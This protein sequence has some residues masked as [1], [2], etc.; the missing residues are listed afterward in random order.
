MQLRK[1][2]LSAV[3][4]ASMLASTSTAVFAKVPLET[5]ASE[6]AFSAAKYNVAEN[7]GKYKVKVMRSGGN[8]RKVSVAFKTAD[9]MAVYGEDYVVLNED[10]SEIPVTE[11]ISPDAE[12][13]TEISGTAADDLLT[14]TADADEVAEVSEAV[15]LGETAEQEIAAEDSKTEVVINEDGEAET[16]KSALEAAETEEAEAEEPTAD[17]PTG[18]TSTGSSLLDAQAEY[19]NLPDTNAATAESVEQALT[20]VNDYFASARGAVGVVVFDEGETEKEITIKIIDNDKPEADKI[21]LLSLMGVNGDDNTSLAA[22]PTAY[23]NILDDEPYEKPVIEPELTNVTLTSDNPVYELKL[24]R[25]AGVDYY[26]SVNVTTTANTAV[27]D[28]DFDKMDDASVAFAPGET[29][30]TVKLSAKN[31]DSDKSYGLRIESDGTCDVTSDYVTV[32]IEAKKAEAEQVELMSGG[33]IIGQATTSAN[34]N[35]FDSW[36]EIKKGG[37]DHWTK[38]VEVAG[39]GFDLQAKELDKNHGIGWRSTSTHNYYGIDSIRCHVMVGGD[40][41]SG[42]ESRLQLSSDSGFGNDSSDGGTKLISGKHDWDYYTLNVDKGGNYY[43]KVKTEAKC[44]GRDN[45]MVQ[46]GNPLENNWRQYTLTVHNTQYF[47]RYQYDYADKNGEFEIIPFTDGG[48]YFSYYPKVKMVTSDETE[49]SGFYA[50]A[51]QVIKPV[52]LDPEQDAKYGVELEGVYLYVKQDNELYNKDDFKDHWYEGNTIFIKTS[53]VTVN[54]DLAKEIQDKLGKDAKDI[55]VMPKFK[56]KTVKVNVYNADSEQT[57]IA[58]LFD[59]ENNKVSDF[60][61]FHNSYEFPLYSK[62]K[63]RAVAAADKK[64]TGFTVV[65]NGKANPYSDSYDPTKMTYSID[66]PTATVVNIYPCTSNQVMDIQYMP[67][68]TKV[69]D[70]LTDRV[71]RQDTLTDAGSPTYASDK[72]GNIHIE[73]VYTGMNWIMRATPPEGYYVKWKNGTGD[74][75]I[76]NG[77]IDISSTNPDKN[78]VTANTERGIYH[79]VYGDIMSGT[80]NQDDTKYYYWFAKADSGITSSVTGNVQR[81]TGSF[82]DVVNNKK[83]KK[84]PAKSTQVSIAGTAVYTDEYGDFEAVLQ[85]VPPADADYVSVIVDN[86]GT[87]YP[88]VALANYMEITLPAY[89]CFKP[90]SL[91]VSYIDS[92]KYPIDGTTVNI[93]NNDLTV[94]AGVE[95]NGSIL[96]VGAKFYIHKENG[97]VIDCSDPAD[98]R[99]ETSFINGIGKLTIKTAKSVLSM[100]DKIYVAFVDQYG[101]K[102]KAM[103]IGYSFIAPLNLRTF[104]FPLIGSTLVD[105][106]YSTATELIGDPLGNISLGTLKFSDPETTS[107]TPKNMDPNKYTYIMSTYRF[108]DYSKAITTFNGKYPEKKDPKESPKPEETSK[109]EASDEPAPPPSASDEPAPPADNDDPAPPAST[110]E[111]AAPAADEKLAEAAKDATKEGG[112]KTEDGGYKTAKSFSWSLSPKAAFAMQISTRKD[113]DGEYR[114]Y[115]EQ[116]EFLV[117]FDFKVEGKITVTLPIGVNIVIT[118]GLSGDVTGV[119]QLKT[120]Y[121]GDPT[122][123]NNKVEYSAASFG[124]FEEIEHVNRTAYFMINPKISLGLG[125]SFASI[126]VGGHANFYFDMDFKFGLNAGELSQHMYGAM[127]YDFDYYVKV[128][129][130]KV[131]SGKKKVSDPIKLFSKNADGPIDPGLLSL[132]DGSDEIQ[133]IPVTREYLN[134]TSEWNSSMD[135]VSLFDIDTSDGTT[136]ALLQ[137]GVYPSSKFKI[138]KFGDNNILMLFIGDV[139]TRSAVNRTGLF[140]SIYDGTNW[141]TPALV[142]DD[143][144]LDDYP[145][146]IDLGDKILVAWSSA[147]RVLDDNTSAPQALTALDIKVSFF[148]KTDKSFSTAE[149]ITKTT[150]ADY[151]ADTEPRA[152]YDAETDRVILYYTKTEYRDENENY[153]DELD[154]LANADSVIAYRFYENGKW[155]D[156]ESYTSNELTGVADVDTYKTNWYGQRFLDTRINTSSNDMLRIIDSDACYYNGLALYAWTVDYDKDL[157]TT[158]DR[159][160]FVQIYNFSE[161]SFTHIIRMTA[162]SGSYSTPHFGR[163]NDNTYLFFSAVGDLGSGEAENDSGIA[164]I[165]ISKAISYNQY[166]LK[167]EDSTKY[168]IL[169]YNTTVEASTDSAGNTVPEHKVTVDI[170]PVYA[171]KVNG[172]VNNYSVDVDENERMYLTWTDS[173]TGDTASRQVFTSIY[174]VKTEVTNDVEISEADWSEPFMLTKAD[175]TAYSNIDAA[176]IDGKLY[177]AANKTPYTE[178]DGVTGLD[179]ANTSM[180][181]LKHTPYSKPV[182]LEED[183]LTIDTKYVYPDTPFTLT[184]SVKN[185]GVKFIEEPVTFTFS[186]T[187]GGVTTD[188]GTETFDGL[189]GAGKTLSASVDITPISEISDDLTFNAVVTVGSTVIN[190]SYKAIKEYSIIPDG[191]AV[192]AAKTD[193]HE[194]SLPLRNDGNIPSESVSVKLYTAKDGEKDQLINEFTIESIA[195]NSTETIDEM[196]DVP[197]E[198]Y[199]IEDGEGIADIIVVVEAGGEEI[200]TLE[201]TAH[202]FFDAQAIETMSKITGVSIKG[203]DKI[204]VQCLNDINIETKITGDASDDAKVIWMSSDTNVVYVRSDGTLCGIEKGTATLTGYVVPDVQNIVFAYDGTATTD[205]LLDSIP[206]NMYKTVTAEVTVTDEPVPTRKPSSGGGSSSSGATPKPTTTVAPSATPDVEPTEAPQASQTPSQPSAGTAVFNDTVN[207]WAREYIERLAAAGIINGVS[208][209]TFEPDGDIT[210]AQFAQILMQTGL[211]SGGAIEVPDYT[212]VDE[213][214]WYYEAVR[215]AVSNGVAEGMS[216]KE[217]APDGRITREQMAAMLNRFITNAGIEA[218]A[219]SEVVFKDADSISDWAK[220]NVEALA[221]TGIISGRD[222]GEFDPQANMTRAEGTVVIC[223]ILDL[224]EE[225]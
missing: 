142:D 224:K 67:T 218:E 148:D 176:V 161:N 219:V 129:S 212:D 78:E 42:F 46:L 10:G 87:Q 133:N 38:K 204:T 100:G 3:I 114:Y 80:I 120:D 109:P 124:L 132:Y 113:P 159:D 171:V 141:S 205:N 49:V 52:S 158:N 37:D 23:I 139:T 34:L 195:E 54:Q 164:Y 130:I 44:A 188:L 1:R 25:T 136:E 140:Y 55:K 35:V 206:S 85:N 76:I 16:A 51:N 154:E 97:S 222:T 126:E 99:F 66:D 9:F 56:Q 127:T 17:E 134:N 221:K 163:Y 65:E 4:A 73:S 111:P 32:N 122:W 20:E 155:N 216:D 79:S 146:A 96:P 143:S 28:A 152:A 160:V 225:K 138:T 115:F 95:S 165:N 92:A 167:E 41:S 24:L 128:L 105:D 59:A 209:S 203:S 15:L 106:A 198:A 214:A 147:D 12:D 86:E 184:S 72:D 63:M 121:N 182:T 199:A 207:H 5:G 70:D 2:I 193:G 22:N 94:E 119:F 64:I 47:Y 194:L 98:T 112:E 149:K 178:T 33:T 162:N 220:A 190:Q 83:L 77:K 62:I 69:V 215:W 183:A 173:V 187:A 179:E 174:D 217:F 103:D 18:R 202:R 36:T 201:T 45:P 153:V 151:A 26:T 89:D 117:G 60:N 191:D 101:K 104:A 14:Q 8:D 58:N 71:Y 27:A 30:K 168:Y 211:L 144:T 107:V 29:E 145:E 116:L 53:G 131:Y 21:V 180:V 135:N 137:S 39:W 102:Y 68:A 156:A 61:G 57:Y 40:G 118:G 200:T 108:G 84:E 192:L 213:S 223:R 189:W 13:F 177:V 166:T 170:K 50:N 157:T 74:V 88:T 93:Q 125:I 48:K 43:F 175:A 82:Y 31:F 19:L 172:Y 169:Q 186:M 81:L 197:D 6:I 185:E 196:V 91:K 210:R 181:M 75:K 150:E 90:K 7:E 11:G 208:D 123:E 110:D